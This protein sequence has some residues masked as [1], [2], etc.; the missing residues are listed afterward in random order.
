MVT[1]RTRVSIGCAVA[2]AWLVAAGCMRTGPYMAVTPVAGEPSIAAV[3]HRLLLI[4]DA[5]DPDPDGEPVLQALEQQVR[6]LPR[7]TTVVFLGDNVYETGMPEPTPLEGTVTEEVLDEALLNMFASRRDS[8]RRVK[9]QVKAI[10]VRGARAIFVPGN[11]DWDQFG[12]GGWKRVR[13]LEA[14]VGQLAKAVSSRLEFLPSGGCP[15]PIPVDV[16]RHARLIVLDTQ[17]WLEQG[18]KPSPENNP[19]GCAQTTEAGVTAALVAA[20]QDAKRAR[21]EAVV[22]GHHPF[23]TRGPH[24][25]YVHP[26]VHLFPLVMFGSYVPTFAHWIPIPG[27]GTLMGA[28]RAWFSP[29]PQDMSSSVNEHMRETLLHAM[30]DAA[31]GG[32]GPLLYAS[33]HEHSLQVFGS[34]RGPRYL[35]VSGMG[36]SGKA[37]PVGYAR[38]S[39]FAHADAASPGFAKVDFLRDGS[40]RLAIV[41]ATSAAPDGVEVWSHV[42]EGPTPASQMA[43]QGPKPR[44]RAAVGG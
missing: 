24:G 25:G 44:Q 7:R 2:A 42:L 8:E 27:L 28:G 10:D 15:G 40:V 17:W 38:D 37:L 16:G 6:L 33:G 12:I 1:A 32:A 41:E 9:T 26:R 29:N 43:D 14:Y 18:E 4:G 20:L 36:S 5:G 19:T 35:L 11:H 22:V 21:R 34:E 13:D 23:R 3:D 30:D 39:L 31:A